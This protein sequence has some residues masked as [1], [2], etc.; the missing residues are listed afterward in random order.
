MS[1]QVDDAVIAATDRLAAV[2]ALWE[3][4]PHVFSKRPCP[5]CNAVSVLA[6]RAFGC[7][8]YARTGRAPWLGGQT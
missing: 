1:E 6:G 2:L 4:D 3:S 8:N 5:T 7:I